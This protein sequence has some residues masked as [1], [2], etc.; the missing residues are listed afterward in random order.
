M[1]IKENGNHREKSEYDVENEVG[2]IKDEEGVEEYLQHSSKTR[3]S[4]QAKPSTYFSF[5]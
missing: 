5:Y 2:E 1:E 3:P 4:S